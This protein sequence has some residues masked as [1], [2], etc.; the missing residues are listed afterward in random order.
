MLLDY[1]CLEASAGPLGPAWHSPEYTDR[2]LIKGPVRKG[3]VKKTR[4]GVAAGQ[5]L[6]MEVKK[7]QLQRMFVLDF[8]S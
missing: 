8:P 6:L 4:K 5:G 2:C 3:G 1:V 7:G